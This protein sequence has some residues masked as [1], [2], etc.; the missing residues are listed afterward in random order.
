MNRKQKQATSAARRQQT[1]AEENMNAANRTQQQCT[2][3]ESKVYVYWALNGHELG[4]FF[5]DIYTQ[6]ERKL[7]ASISFRVLLILLHI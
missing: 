7:V 4:V 5:P 2:M 6:K 3:C 1:E